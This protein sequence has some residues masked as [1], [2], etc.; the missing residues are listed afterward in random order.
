MPP[1]PA[2]S[3]GPS[4][5]R[6]STLA[7][8]MSRCT[9]P[10]WCRAVEPQPTWR[11]TSS[12]SWRASPPVSE[13]VG[14]RA[15]VG[16]AHH[17]VG[18]AVV[19]LARVVHR[20]HVRRLHL[21]QEPTL[22]DE[23]LL[24]VVVVGPVVGEHLDGHRR[25]E[26]VVVARATPWRNHP[27][28]CAVGRRSDR[29]GWVGAPL[30]YVRPRVEAPGLPRRTRRG[31]GRHR[32]ARPAG[33]GRGPRCP[34]VAARPRSARARWRS[35]AACC[36]TPPTP[37]TPA[38]RRCSTWPP[39]SAAGAAGPVHDLAARRRRELRPLDLPPDAQ[40]G[41]GQRRIPEGVARPADHERHRRHP[42]RPARRARDPRARAPAVRRA[43]AA[44]RRLR[45]ALRRDRRAGR[46]PARHRQGAD[47]PRAQARPAAAE[48]SRMSARR[49]PPRSPRRPCWPA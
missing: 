27:S 11:T 39:R 41:R 24:H 9:T 10:R 14:Q 49:T 5:V 40:P 4:T 46:R 43:A 33:Q 25:V 18:P 28:R 29:C 37:R 16:V 31:A 12:A 42:P 45:P 30:H 36:R 1:S 44:A 15:L 23:P 8:L 2:P 47:P 6:N 34:G 32:R 21:A 3:A 26:L 17:Q 35:A 7:G 22:V 13:P 48:R 19:E 20:H 38:R